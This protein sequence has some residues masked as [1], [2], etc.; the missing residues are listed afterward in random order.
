MFERVLQ[1]EDTIVIIRLLLLLLDYV[2]R[3]YKGKTEWANV[4]SRKAIFTCV[5]VFMCTVILKSTVLLQ[6]F[7]FASTINQEKNLLCGSSK[8]Y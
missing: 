2:I 8:R 6:Y 4:C 7:G 3:N 5:S 1:F